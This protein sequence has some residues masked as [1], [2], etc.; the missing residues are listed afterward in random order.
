MNTAANESMDASPATGTLRGK[1]A[2]IVGASRGLGKG[3]ATAFAG[4][5]ARV[6][7]VSRGAAPA[8]EG[9]G[10][11]VYAESADAGSEQ[12]ATTLLERHDPD[13]VV[14]VAGAVPPIG[15][16]LEQTWETF[17]ANWDADVRIAFHWLRAALRKPLKPG[18]RVIV[19]S[20][21]AAIGGSP[22]SGG[23]AGAKATQRFIAQYAQDEARRAGLDI[24]ISSVL[25][26]FAPGTGVGDPAV[27][28][29]ADRAGVGVAEYL[30]TFQHTFGP[31]VTPEG[32]GDAI[33]AL[34]TGAV[35]TA[36]PA[37][38]LTGAGLQ[39]IG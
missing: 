19:M 31:V 36:G 35:S 23:Y 1:V 22:L 27:R 14:L 3:I 25:P 24:T 18:A 4:A 33:I 37:Y 39:Q 7:T 32:A 8:G 29:Y 10:T 9:I 15:T 6:V 34:A 21:G 30:E 2:L 11:A 12:T 16:L 26:R 17:S 13:I 20:S 28:A 5:G 38:L